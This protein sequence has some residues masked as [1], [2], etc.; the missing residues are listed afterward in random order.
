MALRQPGQRQALNNFLFPSMHH[1]VTGAAG[2]IGSQ[3]ADSL[4]ED[5]ARV[6]GVDDFFLGRPEHLDSARS[7]PGFRF[8]D[9]DISCPEQALESLRAACEWGGLPDIIW[10][11]AANSDIAAGVGDDSVDFRRTLQTTFAVLKAAKSTGIK[12]I[13]FASTSAVYGERDDLLTEDSGP[14]LPISN[15]GATKLAGEALLSAAAER[16]LERIWIFRFPNVVGPRAT[17]GA[18]FD[19]IAQLASRPASLKVLGDGSQTKP[20]LHVA[21]LIA[22]MKFIVAEAKDRRNVFNIGPNSAGTSV[23]FIAERVIARVLPGTP[24]VY[25]GGD[26]G[27]VGDVP[28]FCY[29]TERLARLGWQPRLSSDE[30]VLCAID[31][32]AGTSAP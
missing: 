27:W 30:A 32:I 4:L 21:E 3:L 16:F 24:I 9:C 6:S 23:T 31:E 18:I 14:L 8:F 7:N 26:R 2:F 17:H 22:A 1:F 20:Y 25:K 29:S 5:G 28:R 13:G 10:H 15:Y 19:L 11:L 12:K